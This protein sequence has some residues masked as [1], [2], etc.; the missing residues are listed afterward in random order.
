LAAAAADASKELL[1]HKLTAPRKRR[2]VFHLYVLISSFSFVYRTGAKEEQTVFY[3]Y[4]IGGGGGG[5]ADGAV[6]AHRSGARKEKR[7]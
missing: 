7:L 1:G 5:C 6:V 2:T 3:V 4:V